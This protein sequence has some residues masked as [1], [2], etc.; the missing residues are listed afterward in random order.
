[1]VEK[2]G[3]NPSFSTIL[4]NFFQPYR[5]FKHLRSLEFVLLPFPVDFTAL[6]FTCKRAKRVR[7]AAGELSVTK[8]N[9]FIPFN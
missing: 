2:R 5:I 4:F 7:P 8:K 9:E 3:F 1:M 6:R